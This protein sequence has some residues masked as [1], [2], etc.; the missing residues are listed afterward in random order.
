MRTKRL[1]VVGDIQGCFT[2]FQKLLDKL[3]F[4][5]PD[6]TLWLAGDIVNR[7]RQS[8]QCLRYA[9]NNANYCKIVLGNHD[10]HLI[11]AYHQVK[12]LH[13]LDTIQEILNAADAD[14]LINWLRKQPL[15]RYQTDLDLAMVHAGIYPTWNIKDALHCAKKAET[16]L[17]SDDYLDFIKNMYGNLPNQWPL[18]N[19]KPLQ[20]VDEIRFII[21]SFTR[22]R[23]VTDDCKLNMD[24]N[25]DIGTQPSYLSPWFKIKN[26]QLHNTKVVF[27]H[28]STLRINN[29]TQFFPIDTGCV[30]GERLTAMVIEDAT[31]QLLSSTC[32]G[33]LIPS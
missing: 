29:P 23:Y 3:H 19:Q 12:P 6:D 26:Q 1:I 5:P 14:E 22:M 8:L 33:A 32:T 20:G 15:M 21:N 13:K 11:A 9:K 24:Y 4:N 10:L 18:K 31:P 25:G 17:Q 16:V 2:D 28:W 7:G 27:G 30:W